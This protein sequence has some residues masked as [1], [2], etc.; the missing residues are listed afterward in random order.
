MNSTF[1]ARGRASNE[2]AE[3]PFLDSLRGFFFKPSS[4]HT[5][6]VI[7]IA[8]GGMIAYIHLVWMM[9]LESFMG[10]HALI[11]NASW[12]ALHR[13]HIADYKWTYL[14]Q[15]ESMSLLRAHEILA[16]LSGILLCFGV[17][18][19]TFAIVA[20]F[21]TL[22]TA[23]RMTGLLFGL[24]QIVLLLA[25][26]LCISRSGN[27]WSFD[28]WMQHRFSSACRSWS[29]F[30]A[31]AGLRSASQSRNECTPEIPDCWSNTLAT[32]LIQLHLC[33]IYLFGGLGKLRGEM[34]WD[35]SAMWYTVASYDYQSM[36]MT[37]TG[38]FA[39]LSSMA[40]H[41][42]LFWEVSYIAMIWPK[43]VRAWTLFVALIVHGGI[44][45]FLGMFTFGL[46]MIVANMAFVPPQ[47]MRRLLPLL[48]LFDTDR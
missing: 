26:Y 29:W 33:V 30:D 2:V 37:W 20:W 3:E 16:C 38:H 18:T 45:L 40:T 1:P 27:V 8:C 14:A 13:G 42:T 41:L 5:L 11:N 35:G 44:A 10:P 4:P 25:M 34:W 48:P 46:M 28:R 47:R 39:I 43:W 6:A 17:Y 19:R 7:R 12:K 23:H 15:T 9:D 22:M 24:D 31:M 32:R 36:D 21:T